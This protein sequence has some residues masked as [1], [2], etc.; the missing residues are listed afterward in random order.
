LLPGHEASGFSLPCP[1][2]WF[3]S[4]YLPEG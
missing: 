3:C 4:L 2:Q 1:S